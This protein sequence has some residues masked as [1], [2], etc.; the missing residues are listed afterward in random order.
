MD[1]NVRGGRE[2][3][4]FGDRMIHEALDVWP[5][6]Q[7]RDDR[8]MFPLRPGNFGDEAERT[9]TVSPYHNFHKVCPILVLL[10]SR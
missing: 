5:V 8:E 2:R 6:E 10:V 3:T 1:G 7:A 4:Q 9:L